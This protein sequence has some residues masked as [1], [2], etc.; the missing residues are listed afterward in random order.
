MLKKIFLA[1][2]IIEGLAGVV[3]IFNPHLLLQVEGQTVST[4][5][6]AKLY[7]ILAFVFG[8]LSFLLYRH[9]E[10]SE[11]YR[12]VTVLFI[13]FHFMIS[14]QMYGAYAQGEVPNVGAFVVHI[15]IACIF[16]FAYM[17][18]KWQKD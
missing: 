5:I 4:L 8:L 2:A 14:M 9:F 17:N 16:F 10:L 12:K 15:I 18:E 7:G 11:F 6:V 1:H 3:L 13:A